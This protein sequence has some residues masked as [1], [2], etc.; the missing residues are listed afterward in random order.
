MDQKYADVVPL[1]EVLS[2][3]RFAARSKHADA[4]ARDLGEAKPSILISEYMRTQRTGTTGAA[5]TGIPCSLCLGRHGERIR[6]TRAPMRRG[7]ADTHSIVV[8]PA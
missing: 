1:A 2:W 6:K 3:L 4:L 7:I 8:P 5:C